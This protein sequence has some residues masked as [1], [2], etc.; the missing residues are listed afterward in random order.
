MQQEP[1]IDTSKL[2]EKSAELFDIIR[3]N[4]G[5][6][7][8]KGKAGIAKSAT[9]KFIADNVYY[10]GKPLKFIDLRLSQMDETHFG[11]PYRSKPEKYDFEVMN[12]ASPNWFID[13]IN[14]P[15]LINFEE[16]NR[17]SQDVQNAALQILCERT[18]NGHKLPDHVFM[19]A[20]GNMG[21]EDGCN[22]QDFD[23]ALINR[24]IM[25]DFDMTFEEWKNNYAKDNVLTHIVDFVEDNVESHYYSTP[26]YLKE[27]E[28]LP[29]ATP[30]SWT[31]LS[32]SC[33][34]LEKNEMLDH[35]KTNAK[36][37]IGEHSAN[38]FHSWLVDLKNVTFDKII[39]GKVHKHYFE[40][41]DLKSKLN[42]IND[43][44]KRDIYSVK[45]ITES[46][47]ANLER[48][49]KEYKI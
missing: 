15:C 34:F 3:T 11:F 14:E 16:L 23:N 39:S 19:I 18:L 26:D 25:I 17:C 28:G 37:F 45:N 43:L 32:N 40:E 10:N 38:A 42:E 4:K 46:Q 6:L 12:F 41:K 2:N 27:N 1:T 47:R 33:M 24:L 30:R 48:L 5:V 49:F 13:A 7:M 36:C 21:E 31:H 8:L 44:I 35:V 20:T 22:V 29:F 9:C